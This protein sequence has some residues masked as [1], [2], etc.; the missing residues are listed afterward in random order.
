MPRMTAFTVKNCHAYRKVTVPVIDRLPWY[1]SPGWEVPWP[2]KIKRS[3][4]D[5]AFAVAKRLPLRVRYWTFMQLGATATAETDQPVHSV[6]FM[7][8]VEL[9]GK[10]CDRG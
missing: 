4:D 2:E 10:R 1:I 3:R 8:V 6:L 5:L 7:D 9:V